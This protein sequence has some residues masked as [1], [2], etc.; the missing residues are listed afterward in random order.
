MAHESVRSA[1]WVTRIVAWLQAVPPWLLV[2]VA[3]V[4]L[5]AALALTKDMRGYGDEL[6]QGPARA[7]V[8]TLQL[9]F[10]AEKGVRIRQDWAGRITGACCP[11]SGDVVCETP[12]SDCALKSIRADW[13]FILAYVVFGFAGLIALLRLLR[14][15]V[16]GYWLAI[17]LLPLGAGAL[18]VGENLLHLRFIGAEGPPHLI[19]WASLL[20]GGKLLLLG[21]ALVA[22]ITILGFWLFSQPWARN[23][24]ASSKVKRATLPE[25][26]EKEAEYLRSRR[27][28]VSGPAVAEESPGSVSPCRA[29][30][31]ARL[32]SIWACCRRC[33]NRRS[34]AASII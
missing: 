21:I 19:I 5:A 25:V 23:A 6:R 28:L 10:S 22:A 30:V 2:V 29:A 32:P 3:F 7:D 1:A 9:A 8:V 16:D 31:S 20:A 27:T 24:G 15:P 11:G 12:V 33:W 13:G 4:A 26:L 14:V 34:S 17:S 18:D